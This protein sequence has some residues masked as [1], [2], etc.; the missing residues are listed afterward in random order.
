M[1]TLKRLGRKPTFDFE[2]KDHVE[3]GTELGI[4]D[5]ETASK[6]LW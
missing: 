5:F 6:G 4:L 2:I 1:Y 3:L